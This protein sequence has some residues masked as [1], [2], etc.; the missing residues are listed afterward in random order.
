MLIRYVKLPALALAMCL[1]LVASA[2]AQATT[3]RISGTVKDSS[4][5]VLPGATVTV[6]ETRTGFARD[7]VTG[8]DGLYNFVSPA[9]RQLH[10]DGVA[11]RLQDGV[12]KTGHELVADGR[13]TLDFA[14]GPRR[15][16]GDR[17]GHGAVRGGQPHLG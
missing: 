11:R 15:P 10:R 12:S 5:G 2:H 3:G 16:H 8:A 1:A 17:H 14:H 7:E 13:L 9:A 4:G 6:T